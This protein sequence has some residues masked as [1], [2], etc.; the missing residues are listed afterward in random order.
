MVVTKPQGETT[1]VLNKPKEGA[2]QSEWNPPLAPSIVPGVRGVGHSPH[3]GTY[4][5]MRPQ[6]QSRRHQGRAGPPGG[7]QNKWELNKHNSIQRSTKTI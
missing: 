5:A 6:L 2:T 4:S 1:D 3:P 7:K